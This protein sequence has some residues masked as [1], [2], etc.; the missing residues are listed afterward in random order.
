MNLFTPELYSLELSRDSEGHREYKVVHRV[1][2]TS[3]DDGPYVALTT[4]GVPLP[5]SFY[6]FGNDLDLWAWCRPDAKVSRHEDPQGTWWLV[7]QTF[8]SKPQTDKDKER[9]QDQQIEDPLMEPNKVSGS[10]ELFTEEATF[11]K[12]GN[13]ITSTSGEQLRGPSVEFDKHKA[14][15]TIEQNVP[16]LQLPLLTELNNTV[17]DAPLWG[18]PARCIKLR[19]GSWEKRFHGQC[20]IYYTRRLEFSIDFES[21]DRTVIDEGS[22]V[23]NGRWGTGEGSEGTGWVEL[24]IDGARPNRENPS[25]YVQFRD[26]N[27]DASRCIIA[28]MTVGDDDGVPSG[29]PVGHGSITDDAGIPIPEDLDVSDDP[30]ELFIQKYTEGNFLLLGIPITL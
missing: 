7:E 3:R 8:S 26:R 18:L 19:I 21:F 29:Y 15:V 6:A 24:E 11:D 9:C 27:G 12:D 20:S 13:P 16:D 4:P 14:T 23:L 22:K 17:N 10:F 2:V 28:A 30:A 5:G 1:R 25:H